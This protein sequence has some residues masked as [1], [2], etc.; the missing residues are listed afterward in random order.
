MPSLRDSQALS[1]GALA[2][3]WRTVVL[4]A[5]NAAI[6]AVEPATAIRAHLRRTASGLAAD[7]WERS[8][9]RV[10]VVGAGKASG[11]MAAAT[12]DVLAGLDLTGLVVVKDGHTVPTRSIALDEASHP[13]PDERGIEATRR[14]VDIAAG[15]AAEDLLLV[16]ISGGG[17]A[18]LT[19]PAPG[20]TLADLQTTTDALLRSGA[21]IHELNA[22]R[23]HL[24]QVKGGG[25]LARAGAAPVLTLA[26][27]D[28][29]GDDPAVIASGPS[30]ADPSTFA[31]ATA[32][33]DRFGLWPHLPTPVAAHLHAG[34]R[35]EVPETLK[36]D[37]PALARTHYVLVGDNRQAAHAAATHAERRGLAARVLTT[38]Q[39][40]E[41]SEVGRTLACL[42]REIVAGQG[43]LPLPACLILGG[44]TTVTVRGE[45]RGGRNQE[46]ALA[47]AIELE[48][49]PGAVVAC[50]ATDGGDG[51]TDSAGALVDGT[52]LAR[53]RAR[54]L[55]ATH[56]LATND[57]YPFFAALGDHLLTGPTGTNV[58]DLYCVFAFPRD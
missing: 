25:L 35:G 11:V 40:G 36:P 20:L 13:I 53:A 51:P 6:A 14:I 19:W 21:T 26:L 57:A 44:E 41:A 48:G 34:L 23:K 37:H 17:S 3:V 28:V 4:E 15:A 47:A 32:V 2:P 49:V 31:D 27:S 33:I 8:C 10:L 39:Q 54:G 43:P 58:C 38:T 16:L 55:D 5:L 22:V 30:V 7:T 9:R 45:G 50:L 1:R 29:V 42:A 52:T 18:L 24:D 46:A 12:E 56:A